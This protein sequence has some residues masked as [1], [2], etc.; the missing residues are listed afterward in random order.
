MKTVNYKVLVML[1]RKS[2]KLQ[3]HIYELFEQLVESMQDRFLMLVGDLVSFLLEAV[4]SRQEGI[5]VIA[6][7]II[8][9]VEEMSG[10]EIASYAQW[11]YVEPNHII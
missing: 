11:S 6:R 7:R 1:K 8:A 5:A 2:V 3:K 9:K 4:S 10:E